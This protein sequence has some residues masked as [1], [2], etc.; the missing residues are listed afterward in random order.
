MGQERIKA[1]GLEGQVQIDLLDYRDLP[2]KGMTFDRAVSVGMLEHV[3]RSQYERYMSVV[4]QVLKDK[5]LF[6]LH[7]ISGRD[8]VNSNPWMRKYIFPGGTLPTMYEMLEI[9]Y[10]GQFQ[11]LDVE[12][13][14]AIITRRFPAGTITSRRHADRWKPRWAAN[15]SVCGIFTSAAALLPSISDTSMWIRCSLPREPITISQ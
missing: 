15:S 2:K 14:A 7:F 5:G 6:L 3:G 10:K 8:K 1:L 4:E 13:L 12:S 11:L 9:A